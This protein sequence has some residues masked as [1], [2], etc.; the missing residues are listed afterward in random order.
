MGLKGDKHN[1]KRLQTKHL[2]MVDLCLEGKTPQEI[3]EALEMEA[4][5]VRYII[6]SPLF[7][8]RLATRRRERSSSSDE[9]FHVNLV[10]AKEKISEGAVDAADKLVGLL[11]SESENVV[12]K[13]AN[14]ILGHAFGKDK[15][16]SGVGGTVVHLDVDAINILQVALKESREDYEDSHRVF[17]GST[18]VSPPEAVDSNN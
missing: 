13:S 17:A 16:G 7:Q 15:D 5:S 6:R 8:D 11:D 18:D 1:L 2:L 12:L 10:K 4:A 14:S 9:I 3:G